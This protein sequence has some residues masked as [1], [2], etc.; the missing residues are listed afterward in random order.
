MRAQLALIG[1]ASQHAP[2]QPGSPRQ[3]LFLYPHELYRVPASYRR[4]RVVAGM[5]LVTQAARDLVV[6]AG[7]MAALATGRDVALVSPLR[8]QNLVLE[9]Y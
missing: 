7:D 4:L 2:D 6:G 5:A 9:L 3:R 8:N 1:S